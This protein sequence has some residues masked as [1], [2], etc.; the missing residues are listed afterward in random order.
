MNRD[1]LEI[2]NLLKTFVESWQSGNTDNLDD[3]VT[4]DVQID[5]DIFD[6]G[7]DI[8]E[9]KKNLAT[10]TRN[11]TYS[12]FEV[13]NY[14]CVANE[15]EAVQS[16]VISGF[17]V[18]EDCA[19][20][21]NF[22]FCTFMVNDLVKEKQG[23]KYKNLR[24]GLG[25]ES[26]NHG[27][28]YST[29]VGIDYRNGD[30]SFVENWHLIP[31][32]VGWHN[33]SRIG[34]VVPEIDAPWYKITNRTN[35]GSDKEQI[36]E[37]LYKYCF[38]MDYD[39]LELYDQVYDEDFKAVYRGAPIYDKRTCT[40]LLKF[41]RA[42]MIGTGHIFAPEKIVVNGDYAYAH[43]Y[44]TGMT[45]APSELLF[46]DTKKKNYVFARYDFKFVKKSNRWLMLNLDYYEGGVQEIER[47]KD[48]IVAEG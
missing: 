38:S 44:R 24:M 7:I 28:L 25:S 12:R 13:Y 15:K 26:D 2:K 31:N 8:K 19:K 22:A 16:A 39:C 18:D 46:K 29:G 9:L 6:K 43:V 45:G 4:K 40:A 1:E 3:I 11:V 47:G 14:V 32:E 42:G 30:P 5:F 37:C 21:T 20:P 48:I 23:W 17:F 34:S 35:I 33:G 27:R 10:R 36:E 41:E